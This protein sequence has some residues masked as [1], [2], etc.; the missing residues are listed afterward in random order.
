M[1]LHLG[2]TAF[3]IKY[4]IYFMLVLAGME[5]TLIVVPSMGLCLGFVLETVLTTQGCF[6]YC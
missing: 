1:Y 6:S 4:F 5:L 3:K 2:K